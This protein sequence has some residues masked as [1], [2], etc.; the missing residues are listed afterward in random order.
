MVTCSSGAS[1]ENLDPQWGELD[2]A[3][4]VQILESH[5]LESSLVA[6]QS[7]LCA[8]SRPPYR[9]DKQN[10]LDFRVW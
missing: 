9:N 4:L 3:D 7:L 2:P 8:P 10:L 5:I 6:R 1:F